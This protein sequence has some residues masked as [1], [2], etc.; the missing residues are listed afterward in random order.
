MDAMI[1]LGVKSAVEAAGGEVVSLDDAERVSVDVPGAYILHR[2][3]YPRLLLE[4]DLLV[5]LA[6]LK[7]H[8]MTMVTLGIKN[9]QGILSDEQKYEG[10]RDDLPQ[11]L[12]DIH[13]VR[14]PDLTIIDGLIAMEGN[15]AGEQGIAV[16]MNLVI[17]GRD[18]VAVD[19]VASACMGIEDALDVPTT[20]LAAFAGLGNADLGFIE[21]KG[22]SIQ[23]VKRQFMLP[24]PYAK[25]Y[26]RFVTG[27]WQN[28]RTCISGACPMCWLFA[29]TTS[30]TLA[31]YP[32]QWMLV[33]GV[34]PKIPPEIDVDLDHV[35]LLGDC[36][37]SATGRVKEL[38]NRMLLEKKGL[39]ANGCPP[40]RPAEAMLEDHLVKLGLTTHEARQA[41][42]RD[43]QARLFEAYRA[44]DPTWHPEEKPQG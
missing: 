40:Y 2:I 13:R 21:V 29:A 20:R 5:D 43:T 30:Y 10:H 8:T 44:V 42:F 37:L 14:K 12:A 17:T 39:L 28:I 18:V 19:A 35:I 38:R 34:D 27:F 26:D 23:E 41:K 36:A 33:V 16:P 15:G 3:D 25:P 1:L 32:D 31:K 6:C 11:H 9:F 7:T 22:R 4:A 24:M